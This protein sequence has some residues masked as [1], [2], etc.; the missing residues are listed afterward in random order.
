MRFVDL[1]L[2][3]AGF[4]GAGFAEVVFLGGALF[5]ENALGGGAEGFPSRG[6]IARMRQLDPE[7][8]RS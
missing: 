1:V 8:M 7:P 3:G 2:V 6:G 4:F 5:L